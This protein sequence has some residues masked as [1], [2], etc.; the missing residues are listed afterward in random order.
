[1][2]ET[3]TDSELKIKGFRVLVQMLGDVNAERFIALTIQEPHD[4][5]QWRVRNMYVGE[6]VH[7]VAIRARESGER[8]RRT[9]VVESVSV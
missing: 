6:S 4:Y 9:H 5:T 8:Y 7:D 3:L 2:M 1:M